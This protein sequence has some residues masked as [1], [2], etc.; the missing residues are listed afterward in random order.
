MN[1]PASFWSWFLSAEQRYRRLEV[2][3]KEALLDEL[4]RHLHKFSDQL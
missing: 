3:E 4:Q 1:N 2:P